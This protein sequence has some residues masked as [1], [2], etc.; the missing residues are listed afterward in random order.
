MSMAIDFV[1][2]IEGE[3]FGGAR[4]YYLFDPAF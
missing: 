1:M 4:T 2:T 3:W